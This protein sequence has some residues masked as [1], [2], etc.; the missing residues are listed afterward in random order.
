MAQYQ[1]ITY[2]DAKTALAQRLA[3]P[4]RVFWTDAEIG[5]YLREA[6]RTWNSLTE[7]WVADY[8]FTPDLN[9]WYNLAVLP[10]SPRVRTVTDVELYT[11]MQYQLLEPPT[12][13]TWT[14]TSQ[15]T[16]A[17]LSGALQRRRDEMIQVS[18]CNIAQLGPLPSLPNTRRTTFPD[19]TLEP[20]RA[21]F[22]PD[23]GLPNTMT[24]EDGYAWNQFEADHIQTP[25]IP[26]AWGVIS[27]PP[28]AMDVDTGPNV[29]GRYDVLA[30]M[31][32]KP[33]NPPTS[34][35]MGVPDDW[36]WIAKWGALSDL[37]A[38]ESEATD[39]QRAAYCLR[40]Y[41]DGLKIMKASNWLLSGTI[42]GIPVDTPS[43]DEMDAY[44]TEWESTAN[45][46]PSIVTAGMDFLAPC[47]LGSPPRGVSLVLVGNAPVPSA[48]ADFVQV[49][50]DV[51][52][53]VLDYAQWLANFK[54]GGEDWQGSQDLERNFFTVA[55][56][57]NTRLSKMGLFSD[58]LHLEGK[59]QDSNQPR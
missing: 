2:A 25:R 29:A 34:T 39:R 20:R 21:R 40:R 44:A 32:G 16:I 5:L 17:D 37:L 13:G 28:L 18:G 1:W 54:M 58:M 10:G 12:G 30:L 35:L 19:S 55:L 26:Q 22:M 8:A 52:D 31:A 9:H 33:F 23:S 7:F 59:R 53:A 50:Q 15:F 46:W 6:L 4:A 38:R 27:G 3:D 14:G 49:S 51:F 36:T 47:P 45:P 57:T 56:Q 41:Q 11:V 42:N 24:R 48:D 43:V